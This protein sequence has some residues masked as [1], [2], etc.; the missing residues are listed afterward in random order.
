MAVTRTS[1]RRFARRPLRRAYKVR[2]MVR[3]PATRF[4]TRGISVPRNV[5]GFPREIVT[6]LRYVDTHTIQSSAGSAGG[7]VFRLN[8][9][10]DPDFTGAG[11]QPLYY[12]QFTAVYNKYV[13][14][15]ATIKVD[16][17]PLSDD[18][19]ITTTGPYT[20]GLTMNNSNNWATN[21]ATLSEQSGSLTTMVGRDKGTSVR[22]LTLRFDTKRDMGVSIDDDDVQSVNSSNPNKTQFVYVWCAD[23]N[24]TSGSVKINSTITYRVKFFDLSNPNTS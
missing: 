19:E 22:S 15:G 7:Q 23:Q 1:S 14:I 8:S 4:S 24:L 13:V 6:A 2:A 20:V 21:G 11:H 12:D 3:S 17:S 16:F 9:V 18:T 10:Y 5:F